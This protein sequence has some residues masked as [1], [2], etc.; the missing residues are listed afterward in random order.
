MRLDLAHVVGIMRG[1]AQVTGRV[2]WRETVSWFATNEIETLY[3]VGAGKVLTGL[4]RRIERSLSGVAINAP[5]D[6][7]AALKAI[8]G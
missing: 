3:E 7:D 6:I 2:R 5:G 1:C 4:A 8:K